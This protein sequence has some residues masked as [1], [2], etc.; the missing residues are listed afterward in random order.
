MVEQ[1]VST[2][3][4]IDG[5]ENVYKEG[6]RIA[7]V[8]SITL[9]K[10]NSIMKQMKNWHDDRT[11]LR[12]NIWQL[13]LALQVAGRE[14]DDTLHADPLI[15]NQR[16]T[17]KRLKGVNQ[18]LKKEIAEFKSTL[19]E[20]RYVMSDNAWK[21]DD[22]LLEV[23]QESHVKEEHLSNKILHFESRSKKDEDER[24]SE[25]KHFK[26]KLKHF[27]MIDH[28]IEIVFIDIVN[29]VAETIANLYEELANVS[30]HL[31]VSKLKNDSL[32]YEM[33]KLRAMLR[34]KCNNS[35]DYQKRIVELDN[36]ANHLKVE[37]GV[38]RANL[39]E[40]SWDTNW[41][42][43]GNLKNAERLAIEL[44]N[45]LKNDYEAILAAGD[46]DCLQYIKKIIGLRM[47]LKHLHVE[48]MKSWHFEKERKNSGCLK[49]T[50]V[51][52]DNLKHICT[53]IDKFKNDYVTKQRKVEGPGSLQ[54]LHKLEELEA[55]V[56]KARTMI[57][58]LNRQ[59][60]G[61]SNEGADI[62]KLEKL[63]REVCREIKQLEVI[64]ASNDSSSLFKRIE[65]LEESIVR[66][67]VEANEKDE[68]AELI[69]QKLSDA[70]ASLE[71]RTV[72]LKDTQG[73]VT[74]LT[75][76]NNMFK[77]KTKEMKERIS[78]LQREQESDKKEVEQL[79]QI[80]SQ[81]NSMR[82][83]LLNAQTDKERLL[84]EIGKMRDSFQKKNDEIKL[85]VS[86]KDAM[87]KTLNEKIADIG[88]NVHVTSK[89]K[90][91]LLNKMNVY[92][93]TNVHKETENAKEM[94]E[95]SAD[96]NVQ[97]LKE[98]LQTSMQQLNNANR[99]IVDL[100]T[101]LKTFSISKARMEED[102]LHLKAIEEK[103]VRQLNA[104]KATAGIK[105][106]ELTKLVSDYNELN[107]ERI[108]LKNEKRQL[109]MELTNLKMEKELLNKSLRDINANYLKLEDETKEYKFKCNVLRDEIRNFKISTEDLASRLEDAR[110]ELNG[111]GDKIKRLE[112]ENSRNCDSLLALTLKNTDFE[113]RVR[114]LLAERDDLAT[115]INELDAENVALKNQLNKVETKNEYSSI[116]FEKLRTE[117]DKAES[118]NVSLRNKLN[119]TIEN[120]ETL[121]RTVEDLKIKLSNVHSEHRIIENQMKI[122]ELMNTTL[123]KEKESLYCEYVNNLRFDGS[124]AEKE[125]IM[126]I[127]DLNSI[128]PTEQI[129]DHIPENRDN[130][131][132]KDDMKPVKRMNEKMKT[133]DKKDELKKLMVENKALKYE[134]SNLRRQNFEVKVI[135]SRMKEEF[136]KHRF[137][138]AQSKK[139]ETAIRPI[140]NL[141]YNEINS[142]TDRYSDDS[143]G[144]VACIDRA[145]VC[146]SREITGQ[147]PGI[148]IE[149]LLELFNK[150]K[151]ENVALK[152]ELNTLRCN[153]VVNFSE[154]EKKYL[155]L[156]DASEEIQALKVEVTK[157]RDEKESV[158]IQLEV[159]RTK[160]FQLESEKVALK[161]ELYTLRN[162]NTDLRRKADELQYDYQKLKEINAGLKSSIMGAMK[163]I[164][165]HT[166]STTD[167]TD[168]QLKDI[169]KKHIL[170]EELS[171]SI[172][173]AG[174][175]LEEM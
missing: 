80:I 132:K 141:Y 152:M 83:K 124:K 113:S 64:V 145:S 68:R 17:I 121:R 167:I 82:K 138:L 107:D 84:K 89:E 100:K 122:L 127:K 40:K 147:Q 110:A 33:D 25:L 43:Q 24:G 165:K 117:R 88:K 101:E 30:E 95:L 46:P 75:E 54:Y 130:K 118:Q 136:Q 169:L 18:V 150:M 135:L 35:E 1:C 8:A 23:K 93:S 4:P 158:Q 74:A 76:E 7:Y 162:F 59:T 97:R 85:I 155:Q 39:E 99:E 94:Q 71:Q 14:M 73:R 96:N 55:I 168:D 116:K 161:D 9:S 114:V 34:L 170:N 22:K 143:A 133:K 129:K 120:N 87:E 58:V 13:K 173:K 175:S 37:L 50:S 126:A 140:M 131:A 163:K 151:I 72:E 90:M 92:Q 125:E 6:S 123:K 103:L 57:N 15:E 137:E 31:Q 44:K 154:N 61:N 63:V 153:F 38:C 78:K 16:A 26:C 3:L 36:L 48:L 108:Q 115:R 77:A 47:N 53:E 56:G 10:L 19:I 81:A 27:M 159:T 69:K 112:C 148:E 32:H 164:Q 79:E 171:Q 139:N 166:M 98:E 91:K 42:R 104:E 5:N 128:K 62:E 111:A 45:K 70:K 11:K 144:A 106:M 41:V 105:A 156:Q 102:I 20:D 119:E 157:L 49:Q 174:I 172:N 134:L 160:L 142:Y 12:A 60:R 29:R 2:C 65:Q 66:L 28:T 67:K 109:A 146:Y 52:D 51:L 86:E 149:G 21:S